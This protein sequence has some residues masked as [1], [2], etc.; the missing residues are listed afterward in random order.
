MPMADKN[1]M[2]EPPDMRDHIWGFFNE[3]IGSKL[4]AA[5]SADRHTCSKND[6]FQKR[7]KRRKKWN[8]TS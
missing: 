1:L 8:K 5:A 6:D 3:G 2:K 4:L 7:Q